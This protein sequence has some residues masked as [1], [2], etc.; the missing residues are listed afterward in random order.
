MRYMAWCLVLLW[1]SFAAAVTAAER[2]ETL[3]AIG[4]W[5]AEGRAYQT[6]EEGMLFVG[7]FTGVVVL[8]ERGEAFDAAE[9]V[10]PGSEEID[11]ARQRVTSSG[12]C[13]FE[14]SATN[15]V[16]A[17]WQCEG[18]IGDCRGQM[19]I[20]AGTGT[21]EGV[22]GGGEMRFQSFFADISEDEDGEMVVDKAIGVVNWPKLVLKFN[23]PE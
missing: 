14:T 4:P 5:K 19:K 23:D 15:K 22:T 20:V 9:F 3:S 1:A 16:F 21:L 18:E 11:Y 7:T 6:G 2:V 10:C 8:K 13:I 12:L 17:R